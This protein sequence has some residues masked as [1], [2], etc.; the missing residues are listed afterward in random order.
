L[1]GTRLQALRLR[2]CNRL[3]PLGK[4]VEKVTSAAKSRSANLLTFFFARLEGVLH[5]L[6]QLHTW[7]WARAETHVCGCDSRF[8]NVSLC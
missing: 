6:Y 4:S 8:R 3:E 5:R 7:I 2:R 1:A